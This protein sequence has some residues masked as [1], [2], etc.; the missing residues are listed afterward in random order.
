MQQEYVGEEARVFGTEQA[1]VKDV[2]LARILAVMNSVLN[3]LGKKKK[4]TESIKFDLMEWNALVEGVP[5]PD[6]KDKWVMEPGSPEQ[7]AAKWRELGFDEYSPRP[8][9]TTLSNLE[10]ETLITESRPEKHEPYDDIDALN[11]FMETVDDVEATGVYVDDA[12]SLVAQHLFNEWT[13]N[14][15]GNYER[16]GN[17]RLSAENLQVTPAFEV[18][19]NRSLELDADARYMT[20]SDKFNL[21]LDIAR[22]SNRMGSVMYQALTNKEIQNNPV[23]ATDILLSLGIEPGIDAVDTL[24]RVNYQFLKDFKSLVDDIGPDLRA[25]DDK[26][27]TLRNLFESK[28]ALDIMPVYGRAEYEDQEAFADFNSSEWDLNATIESNIKAEMKATEDQEGMSLDPNYK[29]RPKEV[30]DPMGEAQRLMIVSLNKSPEGAAY[31]KNP[32]GENAFALYRAYKEEMATFGEKVNKIYID[33]TTAD[34][35]NILDYGTETQTRNLAATVLY[36]WGITGEDLTSQDID[37]VVAMLPDYGTFDEI[38]GDT[39]AKDSARAKN[40]EREKTQPFIDN[41]DELV[42]RTD[43]LNAVLGSMLN[44]GDLTP[45][46]FRAYKLSSV[47][48]QD[49]LTKMMRDDVTSVQDVLDDQQIMDAIMRA[50]A[51]GEAEVTEMETAEERAERQKD[52]ND[53]TFQIQDYLGRRGIAWSQLSLEEQQELIDKTVDFGYFDVDRALEEPEDVVSV[54]GEPEPSLSEEWLFGEKMFSLATT[55]IEADID[56]SDIGL[57]QIGLDRILKYILKENEY[58]SLM[59]APFDV[60]NNLAAKLEFFDT[61]QDAIDSPTFIAAVKDAVAQGRTKAKRIERQQARI[62]AGSQAQRYLAERGVN[63]ALLSWE[64]QQEIV[65]KLVGFGDFNVGRAMMDR[66]DISLVDV[67]PEMDLKGLGATSEAILGEEIYS[68][69]TTGIEV[70]KAEAEF[71]TATGAPAQL[72]ADIARE[73]GI[74][75]AGVS[76]EYLDYFNRTLL[77]RIGAKLSLVDPDDMEAL[78]TEIESQFETMPAYEISSTDFDRQMGDF[79]PGF[80]GRVEER[81]PGFD[82]A[83]FQPE[84]QEMAFDRPE[85]A[86]FIQQQMMVPGFEQEWQQ[87]AQ[88]KVTRDRGA[89][90]SFQEDRLASFQAA[91]DRA[92]AGGDESVIAQAQTNLDAAEAQFARETAA[93]KTT[94]APT[95]EGQPGM[96]MAGDRQRPELTRRELSI[97]ERE[98]AIEAG[99]TRRFAETA[100]EFTRRQ[101]QSDEQER[102][103]REQNLRDMAKMKTTAG[104]TQQEFFE[105]KLPGFQR[106]FEASPFFRMEQERLEGQEEQKRRIAEEEERTE[107][108]R[109]RSRLRGGAVTVFGRRQ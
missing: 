58:A 39:A 108:T 90:L 66:E 42:G 15:I 102:Q 22:E 8:A 67:T 109:R 69:A 48:T 79:P 45:E 76:M 49:Q 1:Y 95:G 60:R 94:V 33:T 29:G 98:R 71:E 47:A 4:L 68:L 18:L 74:L 83:T 55:G 50:V 27:G 105:S 89:D 72:I 103:R 56:F 38:K 36:H 96:F 80:F 75:H 65:N 10:M 85:L 25:D 20:D 63:W 28:R 52:R 87:A 64:Q 32:T 30:R 107:E 97:E 17:V 84:I 16:T 35:T 26:K 88:R 54:L 14:E 106:R 77:P 34:Y 99:E 23:E 104:M 44:S 70:A 40:V 92:V 73:K 46:Q 13:P 19:H 62:T 86:G 51:E 11:F 12:V 57:R 91:Y 24:E 31:K 61:D 93:I 5:D 81:I 3:P 78:R 2:A 59:A 82:M 53:A 7:L 37:D 21:A 41:R 6:V 101:Q 9:T 43:A 100:E